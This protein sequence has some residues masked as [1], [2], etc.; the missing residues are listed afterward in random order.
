[1]VKTIAVSNATY[2]ELVGLKEDF[3]TKNMDEA[4]DKLIDNYKRLLKQMSLRRLFA[5]NKKDNKINV[6]ELL[7]ER[8]V[9]GWPREFS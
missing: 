2:K 9:Y 1:M 7:N 4:L 5:I 3:D 8:K 6:Q